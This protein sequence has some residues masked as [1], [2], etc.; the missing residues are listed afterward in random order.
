MTERTVS[1]LDIGC[2]YLDVAIE[3][4]LDHRNYFCAIHLS[5]AA[6]VLLGAHLP[7]CKRIWPLAWK[8]EKAFRSE[9]GPTI[10]DAEAR[11]LVNKWMTEI[12]HMDDGTSRTLT[13]DPLAIAEFHIEEALNNYYKLKLP[14]S[15]SVW[16]FEDYQN[17]VGR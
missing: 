5:A 10:S 9:S 6:E 14:K 12:K 11:K 17:T 1:K 7:K 2:E 16:R 13:I 4:F 15:S 3:F 8:A